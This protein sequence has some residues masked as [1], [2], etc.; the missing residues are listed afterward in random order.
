MSIIHK[1]NDTFIINK[2]NMPYHVIE[3]MDEYEL[4]LEQYLHN[5]ELF[6]EEVIVEYVPTYQEQRVFEYPP[7]AEFIDAQV[8]INSSSEEL[9][10]EGQKQLEEYVNKCLM[11]K[12]KYPKTQ[13]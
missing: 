6:K 3:G 4:L 8:K 9:K 12:A 10:A 2:N 7:Y 5:P 11:I 1:K 13:S